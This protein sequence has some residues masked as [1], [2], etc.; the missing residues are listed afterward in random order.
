M[1]RRVDQKLHMAKLTLAAIDSHSPEK[2]PAKETALVES[3]LFHLHI[4]YRAY[5]HELL[6]HCKVSTAEKASSAEQVARAKTMSMEA[7]T[8]Q[9]AANVLEAQQLTS[10]DVDELV[11]LERSGGWPA[12]L[13]AAYIGAANHE[14][15]A[16]A[17]TNA[18]IGLRDI[19]ARMNG[20]VLT[21]WLQQ[22]QILLCRQREHAQE[23]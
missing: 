2:N 14:I 13:Q 6:L 16:E 23:W 9:Q 21:E 10:C 18:G 4:A 15:A 3:A 20:E 12:K 19:T 1:N 7:E 17:V 22:F 11:K 8:A 5:L